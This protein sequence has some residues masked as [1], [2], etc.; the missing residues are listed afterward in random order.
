MY[1]LWLCSYEYVHTYVN[2]YKCTD[3]FINNYD[4][5]W[6]LLSITAHGGTLAP[7][8]ITFTAFVSAL[9]LQKQ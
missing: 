2:M 6:M 3:S 9:S 4:Y 5:T 8:H 1:Y 7:I